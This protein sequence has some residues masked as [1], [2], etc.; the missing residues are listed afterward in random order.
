MSGYV[1]QTWA[2][3]A[4]GGT[5]ISAARLAHMEQGILNG[6]SPLAGDGVAFLTDEGSDGNTGLSWGQSKAT[7]ASALADGARRLILGKGTFP[8][9]A[10]VMD[11]RNTVIEGVAP[12]ETVLDFSALTGS[13]TAL[14]YLAG[15]PSGFRGSAIEHLTLTGPGVGSSVTAIKPYSGFTLNNVTIQSFGTA[16]ALGQRNGINLDRSVELLNCGIGFTTEAD[17]NQNYIGARVLGCIKGCIIDSNQ[18]LI[19]AWFENCTGTEIEV[20]DANAIHF[21]NM[22]IENNRT[23]PCILLSPGSATYPNPAV[24]TFEDSFITQNAAATHFMRVV[25]A[26]NVVVKNLR[27]NENTYAA[28][29]IDKWLMGL[30]DEG[31]YITTTDGETDKNAIVP[32]RI[33]GPGKLYSVS[34]PDDLAARPLYRRTNRSL[35]GGFAETDSTNLLSDS[36]FETALNASGNGGTPPTVTDDADAFFGVHACKAVFLAAQSGTNSYLRIDRNFAATSGNWYT[37]QFFAKCNKDFRGITFRL[38]NVTSGSFEDLP[39]PFMDLGTAYRRF[40]VLWQAPA[41]GNWR[42][43]FYKSTATTNNISLWIDDVA[44]WSGSQPGVYAPGITST[45][46]KGTLVAPSGVNIQHVAAA[47][48]TGGASGDMKVGN[49]KI[50]VNDAGTWKSVAI[51]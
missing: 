46:N 43:C 34:E 14:D 50:W 3:G 23:D 6:E 5:P 44:A 49:G 11:L 2:N 47:T 10:H 45:I 51:A 1:P 12:A 22:W 30:F 28:I 20:Q 21:R 24:I 16:V 41:T 15:G 26:G 38:F 13:S 36:S 29:Q 33:L 7:I 40:T 35:V 9:A 31:N 18:V 42:F 25:Q 19:E 48:P 8:A 39:M 32:L 17:G 4:L 37:L 27:F